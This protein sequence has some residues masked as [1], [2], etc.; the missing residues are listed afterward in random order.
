MEIFIVGGNF[1]NGNKP[2]SV[3]RKLGENFENYITYKGGW[4]TIINGGELDDL[5]SKIDSELIIW[6]PNITNEVPK[7]YPRK[8]VGNV[9][10]VS[11]VIREDSSELDAVSRIFSMRGNAVIAIY[12]EDKFRFKLIDALG[13]VWYDGTNLWDLHGS[14]LNFYEF[15]KKA[16]R[17]GCKK[18]DIK[19]SKV[20]DDLDDFIEINKSLANYIQTSCGERFFGNLSTRCVKLF[21]SMKN[22]DGMFVSPRNVNKDAITS[23]DM[24]YCEQ[25]DN[26]IN[27]SGN[28]KPS[29]DSPIQ[30]KVYN[31][32]ENI[33]YLIHGHAFIDDAIETSEYFVCGDLREAKEVIEIIGDDKGGAIN[34]KN[35]GFL[36]YSDTLDKMKLIIK[37]LKFHYNREKFNLNYVTF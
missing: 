8:S 18:S 21:P 12:L 22:D 28:F 9:L 3:V 2:S 6:T 4:C 5:P 25:G 17:I 15:T 10:I 19:P 14:I 27:Y 30:L 36:L 37:G 32:C 1:G 24:V 29:V 23:D 34:L 26:V 7:Q 33:N 11:K 31:E 35:H 13:N 16:V 20:N